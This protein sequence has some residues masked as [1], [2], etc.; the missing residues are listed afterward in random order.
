MR[1]GR[2]ADFVY[3]APFPMTA[4]TAAQL[5]ASIVAERGEYVPANG[6][7]VLPV[8]A[9]LDGI[10]RS[11]I[12]AAHLRPGVN[13]LIPDLPVEDIAGGRDGRSLLHVSSVDVDLTLGR[14]TFL[15][16]FGAERPRRALRATRRRHP[17][18]A[19]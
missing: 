19:E 8:T 7:I 9:R 2:S 10:T 13:V 6:T 17:N 3:D 14:V 4:N 5:S 11:D 16:R 18:R 12:L 15:G 1:T